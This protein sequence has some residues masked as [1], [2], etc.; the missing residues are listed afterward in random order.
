M[1]RASEN[2]GRSF[3]VAGEV[4]GN[5]YG[6]SVSFENKLFQFNCKAHV[7]FR[8]EGCLQRKRLSPCCRLPSPEGGQGVK[9]SPPPGPGTGTGHFEGFGGPG[10]LV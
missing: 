1:Q 3:G 4:L 2:L 5:K 9:A 7:D 6:F 8:K 10:F